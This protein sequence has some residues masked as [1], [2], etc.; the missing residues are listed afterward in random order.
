M[1]KYTE[2]CAKI[3]LA[4]HQLH[5]PLEAISRVLSLYKNVKMFAFAKLNSSVPNRAG[6][7]AQDEVFYSMAYLCLARKPLLIA[8][9]CATAP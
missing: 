4:F 8:C 3:N 9:R 5:L 6:A 7:C 1:T 2:L